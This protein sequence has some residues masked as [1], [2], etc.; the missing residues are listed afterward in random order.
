MPDGTS[1][2]L[3]PT[4]LSIFVLN[5]VTGTPITRLPVYAEVVWTDREP[6]PA[7][8]ARFDDYIVQALS[9][10]DDI[11]SGLPG[12]IARVRSALGAAL[13][14][15]WPQHLRDELAQDVGRFLELLSEAI[16]R[17]RQSEDVDSIDALPADQLQAIL[18]RAL[19]E[20]SEHRGLPVEPPRELTKL[21]AT[22]PLGVLASD[23]VGYLSF[24]LTRLP[25]PVLRS[26]VEAI[27]ILRGDSN[28][29]VEAAIWVYPLSPT[30]QRFDALVQRRFAHDAI[31]MRLTT[32]PAGH[33]RRHTESR[34]SPDAESWTDRLARLS[35]FFRCQSWR[36]DRGGW[37]RNAA[38]RQFSA[39]GISFPS[40]SRAG[41]SVCGTA[42]A[43][44]V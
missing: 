6:P 34:A 25:D 37:L 26:V 14:A 23:H 21:V 39:P 12:C 35:W 33:S 7:P 29:V 17:A 1:V 36:I 38:S 30:F 2:E 41:G 8:E 27:K 32:R 19:R 4:H 11:C 18:E 3:N 42:A 40:G 44:V 28:A 9:Y 5:G 43:V 22:Y 20:V 15:T 10:V 31:V 16:D 13:T 24:D